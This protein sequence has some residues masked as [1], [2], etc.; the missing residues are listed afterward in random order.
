MRVISVD[1]STQA[2]LCL[3]PLLPTWCGCGAVVAS[4]GG[5]DGGVGTCLAVAFAFAP[6]LQTELLLALPSLEPEA[7]C[8]GTSTNAVDATSCFTRC[9]FRWLHSCASASVR[10]RRAFGFEPASISSAAAVFFSASFRRRLAF[11][12]VPS[13]HF[14]NEAVIPLS[15]PWRQ[16]TL[17]RGFAST[18]EG[19]LDIGCALFFED[20]ALCCAF[21]RCLI[22]LHLFTILMRAG[23]TIPLRQLIA[24]ALRL[25]TARGFRLKSLAVVGF[26]LLRQAFSLRNSRS[27]DL[28]SNGVVSQ[29]SCFRAAEQDAPP[30]FLRAI[31][32]VCSLM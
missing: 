27:L 1:G 19:V 22:G 6:L 17:V 24:V 7:G 32:A 23:L 14:A 18:F 29:A 25:C 2:R 15:S 8:D 3:L 5:R 4:C 21:A 26:R 10:L 31:S 16:C 20:R 12:V 30:T 28:Q 9:F 13:S 11:S